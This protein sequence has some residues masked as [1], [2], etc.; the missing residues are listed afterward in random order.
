MEQRE[1][2]IA[3]GFTPIDRPSRLDEVRARGG[4]LT[5]VID[6]DGVDSE[7]SASYLTAPKPVYSSPAKYFRA[8]EAAA[9]E[10]PRLTSDLLLRQQARVQ[11]LL[12][13]GR[14]MNVEVAKTR[15]G[16]G[17]SQIIHSAGGAS[18]SHKQ[19]S[20]PHLGEPR[21]K[22][23]NLGQ[24]RPKQPYDLAAAGDRKSVV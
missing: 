9:A 16:P 12:S 13:A 18:R 23:V 20:S 1:Y 10:L 24:R 22:S 14:R 5:R 2:S 4:N 15:P 8:A 19:A 3:H 7:H 21:E 6:R 17:A 11:E